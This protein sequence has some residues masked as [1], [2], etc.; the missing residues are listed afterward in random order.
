MCSLG[1]RGKHFISLSTVHCDY[2]HIY[3]L[4]S[5]DVALDLEILATEEFTGE[6]F[7]EE[8]KGLADSSGVDYKV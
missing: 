2:N 8:I 6:Y 1:D 5:L 4:Y 7:L 3:T